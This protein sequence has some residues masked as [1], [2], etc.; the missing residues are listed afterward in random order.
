MTGQMQTTLAR[1]PSSG[2]AG[3]M[4][5]A[6]SIQRMTIGVPPK[7][8]QIQEKCWM[9]SIIYLSVLNDILLCFQSPVT[10]ATVQDICMTKLRNVQKTMTE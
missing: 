1:C 4:R 9:V 2:M 8:T 5:T 7:S 6:H 10:G 3:G